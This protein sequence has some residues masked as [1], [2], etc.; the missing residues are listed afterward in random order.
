MMSQNNAI[1]EK[2]DIGSFLYTLYKKSGQISFSH[3]FSLYPVS[4]NSVKGAFVIRTKI[5]DLS[6]PGTV[7][8]WISL[9]GLI[10]STVSLQSQRCP[11]LDD[12]LYG[13]PSSKR[14]DGIYLTWLLGH[15]A[16]MPPVFP[17]PTQPRGWILPA[18]IQAP[19]SRDCVF[20]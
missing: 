14:M 20:I 17:L 3:V 19:E 8:I 6:L 18:T 4:K 10:I 11:G 13:H 12:K 15:Q 5:L 1:Q 16:P 2:E 7:L 9:P